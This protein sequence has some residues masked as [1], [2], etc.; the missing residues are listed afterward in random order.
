MVTTVT[1]RPVQTMHPARGLAPG[2]GAAAD[3]LRGRIGSFVT[4]LG[5][6]VRGRAAKLRSAPVGAAGAAPLDL[7]GV[8]SLAPDPGAPSVWPRCADKPTTVAHYQAMAD[9]VAEERLRADFGMRLAGHEPHAGV[10]RELWLT[11]RT[12]FDQGVRHG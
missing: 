4:G 6:Y 12:P 1:A 10:P 8:G 3:S 2:Q 9:Q 5:A 7:H 11:R